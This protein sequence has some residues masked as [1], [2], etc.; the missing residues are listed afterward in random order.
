MIILVWALPCII[1]AVLV[2]FIV[3]GRR[4]TIPDSEMRYDQSMESSYPRDAFDLY[5]DG[6]ILHGF[7][8]EAPDSRGLVVISNGIGDGA[9]SHLPEIMCF[10]DEGYDVISYDGTGTRASEGYGV[11]GISQPLIDLDCALDT[12]Q[13][14]EDLSG[15]PLF[16]YGH[17]AGGYAAAVSTASHP[18]IDGIVC[19]CAFDNPLEELL[20]RAKGYAGPVAYAGYPF[21]AVS[22]M[23][24]FPDIYDL[25]AS[26]S[27]SASKVPALIVAGDDDKVVPFDANIYSKQ[28]LIDDDDAVFILVEDDERDGHCDTAYTADDGLDETFMTTVTDFLNSLT[29]TYENE[30]IVS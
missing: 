27:L 22:Y 9:D 6:Y 28:A 11:R 10:V 15:L 30:K 17:S 24:T 21:M 13:T 16:V 1:A 26:S 29:T 8:Y 23:A 3:W 12:I 20:F 2:P 19:L 25:S 7:L 18:E 4:D 14:K 5:A